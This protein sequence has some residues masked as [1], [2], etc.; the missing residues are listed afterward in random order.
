MAGRLGVRHDRN[1]KVREGGGVDKELDRIGEYGKLPRRGLHALHCALVA[2]VDNQ[3]SK[4]LIDDLYQN[5][6]NYKYF[7]GKL[8]SSRTALIDKCLE[9]L[10]T[11]PYS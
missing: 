3:A 6:S 11:Q 9:F 7:F 8:C 5:I 10:L 2:Y 1:D 4:D